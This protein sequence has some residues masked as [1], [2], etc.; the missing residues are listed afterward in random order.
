MFYIICL[1]CPNLNSSWTQ[2]TVLEK[3]R[4]G[5]ELDNTVCK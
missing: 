4:V 1:N 3:N 5:E 2:I